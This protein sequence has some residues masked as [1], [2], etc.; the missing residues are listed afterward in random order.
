MKKSIF[1]FFAAILCATSAWAYDLAKGAYVY[2]EKPSDW[3]ANYVAFMIGHNTWSA[4]YNMTKISNTNLYYYRQSTSETWGGYTQVAFFSTTSSWSGGEGKKIADR[5]QYADK[6]TSVY[7]VN[8]TAKSLGTY[9][10]FNA[11][12]TM[13]KGTGYA[14]VIN[15]TQTIKV[16]LKDGSNWVD[17]TVVPA[18]L[19]ASTYAMTTSSTAVSAASAFLAKESTTVS[20]TVSAAYSATVSLSCTNVLDGYMFEG[21]YN[22]N[23]DKITSYT[24]SDAHTVYARFI[25]SAEETNEV[26]VTYMC[27]A[28]E[29]SPAIAEIVGVETEKSFT[30]PTIIDYNFTGWT[31][32]AG[33]TLKTGAVT[34]ATIGVVTKSASSD[35]TLVA[36]YDYIEPVIKT[37]YCKMEYSWWTQA[38]AAISAFISGTYG[39]SAT[40][41][42]TLMTLAPLEGN[43]WKIDID[44]A[45]YQKVKF[46]RVKS[47]G[48]EDWGARTGLVEIPTDDK[49]LYTITESSAKWSGECS[50]TWSVY[51]AP[52]TAPDRYI[53]G[54]KEL[55]GGDGWKRNEILMTH[56][57]GV[58]THT[59]AASTLAT[60]T[61]Y[62]LKVTDGDPSWE[63]T[64]AWGTINGTIPGVSNDGDGNV[65]FKLS[66]VGDVTVTFDGAKITV[67]TTGTFYVPKTY[68]YYIAGDEAMTGFDWNNAGLGIED[69][70]A[71]GVYSHVFTNL[72]A[73]TYNFRITDGTWNNT[74][75]WSHLENNDFVELSAG[76][77]D[78]NIKL[79]LTAA[80]TVTVNYNKT[81]KKVSIEGL[82]AVTYTDITVQL[83]TEESAPQIWWWGSDGEQS[84]DADDTYDYDNSAPTMNAVAGEDNWYEWT[85][86]DVATHSGVI[87]RFKNSSTQSADYTVYENTCFDGRDLANTKTTTC[88]EVPTTC[89]DCS[90]IYLK[91]T[92]NEWLPDNE[93]KKTSDP[94]IVTLSI[95]LTRGN[96][97]FKIHGDEW[98]G[99]TGNLTR[100][101]T[102]QAWTYNKDEDKTP[103]RV[104]VTG[105]YKFS[106]NISEHKLTV[107]YPEFPEIINQP[108]KIYFLP[109]TNWRKDN[110]TFAA[111]FLDG[112]K[113]TAAKWVAFTDPD[114]DG[115]YELTNDKEYLTMIFCRMDPNGTDDDNWKNMW[116]Q[117]EDITIPNTSYLNC[118]IDNL[119]WW[120]SATGTWAMPLSSGDNSAAITAAAEQTVTALVNRSLVK[121]D[122]YYTL[123]VP[124]NMPPSLVGK[125]YQISGLIKKN[126]DYVEVNLAE[127]N[128]INAGA[129]YLIVPSETKDYLLVENVTIVNT[130]GSSVEKSISGLSV[131]MQGVINGAGN[132]DGLY[133]VGN[134]GYLYNDSAS[135]LGLRTYFNITTLSGIAPRLRVVAGENVETS[136]ED[137]ITTDAPVKVIENGQLIIIRDGVKYNVQGQKL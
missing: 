18:D 125:A 116:N 129:P 124:F 33:I 53:T 93:F 120:N 16:Q 52:A 67:S 58:Y 26:S 83:Y 1:L 102:E 74:W 113:G 128:Q 114:G 95:N 108:E 101:N 21:W 34:D 50:G 29:V 79:T 27:D 100:E 57:D 37:I 126:T 55:V 60:N 49:N 82:T 9:S 47:D 105:D 127:S 17:A 89:L 86:T 14:A 35:Y 97:E 61:E 63:N 118:W 44:V 22:A 36:N 38:S 99:N 40:S 80:K 90:G 91:G 32:G 12:M 71:D 112:D 106:W 136:V 39:E 54:N 46:I 94:N 4:A 41:L 87:V 115:M 24:V 122:G 13:S 133:W 3:T 70:D 135:K 123:C 2:F 76:D 121:D 73:G 131:A 69:T 81:T 111:F 8:S 104:D 20:A 5:A 19:T 65:C 134:G 119:N 77:N 59:F 43:V 30:A 66:T 51:E 42:G 88:G 15:K 132:T 98:Y 92:F 84:K 107:T 109:N 11:S 68:E 10:L 23:G 25:Q 48:S 78:N 137:I 28:T 31:I 56:V 110:A 64:Q 7:T 117:S 62:K 103:F 6:A 85:I 96:H 72:A 45:R 75:G 130:S